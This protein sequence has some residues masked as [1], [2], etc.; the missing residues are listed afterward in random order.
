MKSTLDNNDKRVLRL[1]M[2]K[3]LMQ[4]LL[5]F[6][7]DQITTALTCAEAVITHTC[8]TKTPM[9]SVNLPTHIVPVL[10]KLAALGTLEM[11]LFRFDV[12]DAKNKQINVPSGINTSD[13]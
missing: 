5:D 6:T 13:Q 9:V 3:L 12:E 7:E 10:M 8:E 4:Q 2:K 1:Y 11:D